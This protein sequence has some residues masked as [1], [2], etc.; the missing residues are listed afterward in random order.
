MFFDGN[1]WENRI[2]DSF[3]SVKN[4]KRAAIT[5]LRDGGTDGWLFIIIINYQSLP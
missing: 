2:A 4:P 1:V 5:T 3:L